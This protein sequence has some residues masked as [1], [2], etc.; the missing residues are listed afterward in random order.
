MR[1]S[2]LVI[3][4]VATL[5]L[6]P[7]KTA[8]G[9]SSDFTDL[10]D[11]IAARRNSS[12]EWSAD[13]RLRGEALHN[14]DLNRGLTP[15]GQSLYPVPVHPSSSTLTHGDMRLRTDLA[16]FSPI[17]DVA[18]RARVDVLDNLAFGSMPEGPPQ[19]TVSQQPVQAL[20]IKR[21]YG[22]VLTPFGLLAAGRM[23]SHWGLGMLTHGGDCFDCD[24]GDAADRVAFV[25]PVLGHIWAV[26]YDISWTGPTVARPSGQRLVGVEPSTDVRAVT[27]ATLRYRSDVS[28]ERRRN[29][30]RATF[31][32]GTYF[33]YRW[34]DQDIPGVY[35]GAVDGTQPSSSQLIARD[36]RA[37][38]VDVWARF[39]LPYLRLEAEAAYL[40]AQIGQASLIPGV[41]YPE[42]LTAEQ[43]GVAFESEIGAGHWPVVGGLDA[44][45]ASG[46]AA[47]CFGA[48]PGPFD[49]PAQPGDLDGPQ[50][51]PPYDNSIKNFRFHPDYR[52]DRILFREIIGTVTDAVYVRPHLKWRVVDWQ[53]G[54]IV[55]S[56]AAV[57]SWATQASSTPGG[58]RPLGIEI[59][60]SLT[61]QSGGNFRLSVEHAV[62][63]PLAGLD[64]PD[65]GLKASSA[66]LFRI[67]MGLGF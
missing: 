63:F 18:L 52:V 38:A 10:G 55:A 42:P 51:H 41:R 58:A 47:P 19:S 9:Q 36:M 22:Q 46:D 50:A 34:Q 33:S 29:A 11:D 25:T 59:D 49:P 24:S 53:S 27:L 64:N 5:S 39:D 12:F 15:S 61:Y 21:V 35:Y 67:T 20:S 3:A 48:F 44:G 6:I 7:G 40:G 54:S 66:Q 43:F 4:L 32:Y 23:G 30:G 17:G 1:S 37:Y 57:A 28:R 56:V 8:Y 16:A 26:A 2:L 62:L 13:F 60:P 14:L 45:F 65:E 31:D